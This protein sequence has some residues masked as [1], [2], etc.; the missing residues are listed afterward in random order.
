MHVFAENWKAK[1]SVCGEE[2]TY[3]N[4]KCKK[5][6]GHHKVADQTYFH[7]GG[8]HLQNW[9]EKRGWSPMVILKAGTEITDPRTGAKMLEA[10]IRV[11]FAQQQVSTQDPEVQFY[12]ET[13]ND[14]SIV[15]GEEGLKQWQKI[16]LTQDQQSEMARAELE[17]L[18]KQIADQNV[19]L[20]QTRARVGKGSPAAAAAH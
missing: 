13:K 15:W 4:W 19:L 16:Y 6:P 11:V 12:L 14:N 10:T 9:R 5:M 2:V 7:L 17:G 18:H 3:P 20:E 8:G 1:C